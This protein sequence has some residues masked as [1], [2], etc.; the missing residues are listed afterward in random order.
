MAQAYH[1]SKF[2][3][4]LVIYEDTGVGVYVTKLSLCLAIL[5]GYQYN[6]PILIQKGTHAATYRSQ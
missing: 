2:L 4:T 3:K 1:N 5:I 6:W